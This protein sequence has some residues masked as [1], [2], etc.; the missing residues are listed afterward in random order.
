MA[1]MPAKDATEQLPGPL[2]SGVAVRPRAASRLVVITLVTGSTALLLLATVLW[3]KYP[4]HRNP[5]EP[6]PTGHRR[7]EPDRSFAN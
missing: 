6:A 7:F 3:F 4:R 2:A 5:A 1:D